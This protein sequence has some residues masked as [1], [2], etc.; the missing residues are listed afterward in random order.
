MSVGE[1]N[2]KIAILYE[3]EGDGWNMASAE[4]LVK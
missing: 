2:N 1:D 3:T 4:N